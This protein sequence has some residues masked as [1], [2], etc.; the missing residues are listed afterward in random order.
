MFKKIVFFSFLLC[1]LNSAYAQEFLCRVKIN[2]QQ[3]QVTD[4]TIF[5]A[6]E[7]RLQDFINNAKWSNE[8]VANNEKIEMN[9]EII[10][11][12][13]DQTSYEYRAS[14]IIQTRRPVYGANYST[15]L[16]SFNDENWDFKYQEQDRI[17]YQDGQFLGDLSSLISF[18]AYYTLALDFDSF[19]LEG[20]SPYYTKAFQIANLAQQSSS[21]AGWKPFEKTVRTRYNLIDNILNE[22]FR[23]LRSAYYLYHRKGMDQFTKDPFQARKQIMISLEQVKKVFKISPNTVMLLVFF[24]AKSDELVNIFKGAEEIEK[25]KAVELLSEINI[26]NI[27][28]YE[29]IK[30]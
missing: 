22:R 15:T 2:D 19:F 7:Q 25:P 28:K 30:S 14:A 20:G 16:F 11:S 13:Y 21:R 6:L 23:P 9:I 12:A 17:E 24:E 1:L 18:Y 4:K 5:R 3:V 10:L 26:A 8:V 27:S 29:K